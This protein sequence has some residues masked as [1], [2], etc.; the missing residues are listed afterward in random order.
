MSDRPRQAA[1]VLTGTGCGKTLVEALTPYILAPWMQGQQALF[2]SDNCTLRARFLQ[3][4]PTDSQHR[5][6]YD[7]W[8]L[9]S[10]KVLPSGVV[11]PRIVELD[12][13]QFNSYA[14]CLQQADMLVANRQFLVNLVQRGD[15]DPKAIGIIVCDE[16]HFSAAASYRTITNYFSEALLCYFT[17]SK[18]RSDSQPLPYVQYNRV[19]DADELGMRVTRYAPVADYE[20]TI[21][22]AWKLDPPPIKRI[23]LQEATSSAFLV[24]EDEEEVEYD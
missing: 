21:Q 9:Y 5:P 18:F 24:L 13:A 3:D 23:C 14:Y 15:I 20:F 17:G 10:L 7:Q 16:A 4:F 11:P 12:A 8:L 1:L 6:L 2:L 22:D 19:E